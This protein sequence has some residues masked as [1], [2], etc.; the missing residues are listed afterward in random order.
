MVSEDYEVNENIYIWKI[1]NSNWINQTSKQNARSVQMKFSG[2]N[3]SEKYKNLELRFYNTCRR[4]KPLFTWTWLNSYIF[5]FWNVQKKSYFRKN[6]HQRSNGL[7]S[8]YLKIPA[9]FR[10]FMFPQWA[11]RNILWSLLVNFEKC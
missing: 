7:Q 4:T 8:V 5:L 6:S 1:F 10:R 9:N 11:Q 2:H 3:T